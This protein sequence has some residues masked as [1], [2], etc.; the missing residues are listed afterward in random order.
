M[1]T[2]TRTS[3]GSAGLLLSTNGTMNARPPAGIVADAV[4]E[5]PPAVTVMSAFDGVAAATFSSPDT[6]TVVLSPGIAIA[7]A[8]NSEPGRRR[9]KPVS[10]VCAI[11]T[12][13]G[14]GA[15]AALRASV[16]SRSVAALYPRRARMSTPGCL[17][18]T[19]ILRKRPSSF[20]FVE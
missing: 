10:A 13:S 14:T 5:I 7:C 6:Q 20:E 9:D 3:I 17:L 1:P 2:R 11:A 18:R 15:G 8:L 12:C 16:I 4:D 19:L